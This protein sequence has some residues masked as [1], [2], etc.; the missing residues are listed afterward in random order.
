V[1]G[2]WVFGAVNVNPGVEKISKEKIPQ[3]FVPHLGFL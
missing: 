1:G 2:G 3:K